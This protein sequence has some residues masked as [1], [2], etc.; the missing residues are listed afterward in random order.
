MKQ[1]TKHPK[2][3]M[4]YA[5]HGHTY[6]HRRRLA[7]EK[8]SKIYQ[9]L[10]ELDEDPRRSGAHGEMGIGSRRLYPLIDEE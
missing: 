6:W 4:A 3:P 10:R 1:S 7:D 9:Q 5:K 2:S 8:Y